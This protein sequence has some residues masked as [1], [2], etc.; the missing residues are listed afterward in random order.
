M[1]Y[2]SDF[3]EKIKIKNGIK[4]IKTIG[5]NKLRN[6][7]DVFSSDF[8]IDYCIVYEVDVL[9]NNCLGIYYPKDYIS[10][11]VSKIL[12]LKNGTVYTFFHELVHHLQ[13]N[14]YTMHEMKTNHDQTFSNAK[15]RV[16]IWVCNNITQIE[17]SDLNAIK[18]E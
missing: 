3:R 16:Y 17:I 10:N 8:G 7:A 1:I 5:I 9:D 4:N 11:T 6:I 12:L 14:T 2:D 18:C 15:S 13:Y